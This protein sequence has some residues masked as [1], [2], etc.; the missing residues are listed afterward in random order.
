MYISP[1]SLEMLAE[2]LR[3]EAERREAVLCRL[4]A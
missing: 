3:R 4:S 2:E 1:G